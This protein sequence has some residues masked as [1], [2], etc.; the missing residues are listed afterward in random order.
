MIKNI[1]QISPYAF[2][3]LWGVEKHAGILQE[4]FEKDMYTLS[5][6]KDFPITEP[7][8][9][10][11]VPCFWKKWF[12][13]VFSNI[14]RDNTQCI[15]SH[16]RFA[17][18]AWLAFFLAKKRRI[19]YI[20]VEHGSNFLIHNSFFVELISKIVDLTIWKYI[21]KNAD[22]VICVSEAWKK[23]VIET[24]WR[25][26]NISVIYRGFLFPNIVRKKNKIPRIGFVGRLTW[27]KNT[28]GLIRALK[29]IEEEKWVLDIVGDGEER[30][31]LE[32]LVERLR[33][34]ERV[35]FL[36]PKDHDW[37]ISNFYPNTDIIVNSSFIECLGTSIIE[38]IISECKVVATNM[39]W[40]PEIPW[41]L[42]VEPNDIWI[43]KWILESFENM[44]VLQ[45]EEIK[46]AVH[47]KFSLEMMKISFWKIFWMFQS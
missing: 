35:K 12:F 14:K 25:N 1:L 37:I 40:S 44:H 24:F 29:M 2:D 30:K 19:P 7:V 34:N 47:E 28:D 42:L 21:L 22:Y 45:T 32:I 4:L 38:G 33:L 26:E 15:I 11:P 27:Y 23:W 9:H 31:K 39:W 13:S 43:M 10:C 17:P 8:K 3:H 41:V 18:T 20:H 36:W 6:W 16:I 5:W 46:K